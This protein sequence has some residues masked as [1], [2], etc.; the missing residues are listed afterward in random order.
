MLRAR[1]ITGVTTIEGMGIIGVAIIGR[2]LRQ[3]RFAHSVAASFA[4]GMVN[5]A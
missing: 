1:A 5:A 3:L 4:F 2:Q